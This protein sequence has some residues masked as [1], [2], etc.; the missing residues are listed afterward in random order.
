MIK[1]TLVG[2]AIGCVLSAPAAFAEEY[3]GFYFGVWGGSGSVDM[4]SKRALDAAFVAGLP[5]ELADAGFTNTNGTADPSDDLDVDFALAS[6]GN[7]TLDDSVSVWGVQVGYRW[8]KYF[9]TEVG[10]ANLGEAS[11]RLP[12]SVAY[13]VTDSAGDA[14]TDSFDAERAAVFTSAGPTISALGMLPLGARFDLHLRLGIYLAD[15]RL[16]NRIRDVESDI[17]NIAHDRTDASETEVYGGIGGAWNINES[18]VLRVEYQKYLD[19]GDDQKTGEG[20]IDVFNLSV[21]FK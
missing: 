1:Q 8:G 20:D 9:A 7:S 18:F 12:A 6:L 17:G 19:V 4:A 21:L 2:L 13:T 16:T 10:Y 11:Y 14:F 15:T 3:K 5:Q